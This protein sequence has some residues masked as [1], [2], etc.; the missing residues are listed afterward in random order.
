MGFWRNKAK[1][2][3]QVCVIL[4]DKYDDDIPNNVETLCKLPGVG[5]K[6]AHLTMNIAWGRQSGI[7]VDTHVHYIVA[8]LGHGH[9]IGASPCQSPVQ[10]HCWMLETFA[11]VARRRAPGETGSSSS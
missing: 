6:M 10:S 3:K 5:P 7:G 4:R 11:V 1:Y 8:R 2:L 9:D